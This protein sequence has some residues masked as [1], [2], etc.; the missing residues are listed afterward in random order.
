M[1]ETPSAALRQSS[2]ESKLPETSSTLLTAG[3]RLSTSSKRFR[4]L[5][6]RTKQRRPKKPYSRSVSTT[7]APTK[8]LDP[9]TKM[10]S[11]EETIYFSFIN[12]RRLREKANSV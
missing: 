8:P 6:G 5:D 4:W 10:R 12:L 3:N 2:R 11:F 1:I 7:F 9:V